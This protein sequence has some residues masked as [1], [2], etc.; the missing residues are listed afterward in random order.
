MKQ[1]DGAVVHCSAGKDT[2][3]RDFDSIKRY[4]MSYRY[5]YSIVSE[6][7][8]LRLIAEGKKVERPWRDI[9]YNSVQE[10]VGEHQQVITGRSTETSGAHTSGYN[11]R[12]RDKKAFLGYC[13]VGN[14]D[15]ET[16]TEEHYQVAGYAI[17]DWCKRYG[18]G[19]DMI[20]AHREYAN[21]TC[22]GINFDM[23]RVR[24]Y[25]SKRLAELE[26]PAPV[27]GSDNEY[28]SMASISMI[29]VLLRILEKL[30]GRK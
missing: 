6:E 20:K 26:T 9:A 21:K 4:H 19:V 18:F 5:N 23:D 16:P 15:E 7:E 10:K 27:P 8:A 17:G 11:G 1:W 22:P 24:Y 13:V 30:F 29:E 3:H 28:K 14:F 25:A 12:D 2:V